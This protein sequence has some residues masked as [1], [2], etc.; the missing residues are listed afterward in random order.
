MH[1]YLRIQHTHKHIV[2]LDGDDDAAASAAADAAG[3]FDANMERRQQ[4]RRS[5]VCVQQHIERRHAVRSVSLSVV[6]AVEACRCFRTGLST[7]FPC[8][9]YAHKH[10]PVARDC[11]GHLKTAYKQTLSMVVASSIVVWVVVAMAWLV[12][13]ISWPGGN[14]SEKKAIMRRCGI[15]FGASR[16]RGVQTNIHNVFVCFV[17][18]TKHRHRYIIGYCCGF[19]VCETEQLTPHT[20]RNSVS[21][22]SCRSCHTKHVII[23]INIIAWGVHAVSCSQ[24]E[25]NDIRI[26]VT[27]PVVELWDEEYIVIPQ[28]RRCVSC[29]RPLFYGSYG[30]LLYGRVLCEWGNVDCLFKVHWLRK[31]SII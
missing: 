30:R 12:T 29:S 2:V 14:L 10:G 18:R 27:N 23:A 1:I 24:F 9:F 4:K 5:V 8:V 26:C 16:T 6:V 3:R 25:V 31:R 7:G 20:R 17:C 28:R 19:R 15:G 22:S 11:H 13:P 21:P